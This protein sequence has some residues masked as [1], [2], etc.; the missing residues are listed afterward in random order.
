[1]RMNIL[2]FWPNSSLDCI[3]GIL[4]S[5]NIERCSVIFAIKSI[6]EYSNN[7]CWC[8]KDLKNWSFGDFCANS[9]LLQ[10]A[11]TILHTLIL[12]DE[13]S[14]GPGTFSATFSTYWCIC[15][16]IPRRSPQPSDIVKSTFKFQGCVLEDYFRAIL[17]V[18]LV[19]GD[20]NRLS[21]F[22]NIFL[23]IQ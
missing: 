5:W 17:T 9:S 7:L 22:F 23:Q 12:R 4:I 20:Q 18:L 8:S 1:M 13:L 10:N 6:L 14:D 11:W 2:V 3:P 19:W 15:K 16:K 21:T